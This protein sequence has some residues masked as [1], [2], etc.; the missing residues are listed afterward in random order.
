MT[1]RALFRAD[2]LLAGTAAARPVLGLDTSLPIA[3]LAVAANGKIAATLERPAVS[4]GAA[5]PQAAGELLRAAGIEI[6][7]LG[8][9]AVGIGPGSFTGLRVGIA[10]AKGIALA[11]G[12]AIVGVPSFDA[13]AMATQQAAN[14]RV[15]TLICP[16][17]DARKGEFYCALYRTVA[18]GLEKILEESVATLERLALGI[19]GGVI[20]AG[21]AS[22][23]SAAE[24]L[25]AAGR[26]V[27]VL[28][29]TEIAQRGSQI[30]A[31]GA[32]RFARGDSDRAAA[33]EPLYIR[34]PAAMFKPAAGHPA[35]Q[36]TEGIWNKER[37]NSFTG[38]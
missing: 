21:D 27:S 20:L 19:A 8:A 12:C 31:I 35:D 17:L 2:R 14:A 28:D 6:G 11:T 4:H 38:I 33:L 16:V 30:A 23:K 24:Y 32:A 9:I 5:L 1:S 3:S 37:K 36:S 34:P 15:G 13:I 18:D 29:Y 10:Y 26:T 22:A 7:A 25:T